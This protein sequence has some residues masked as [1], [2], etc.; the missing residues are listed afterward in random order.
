[1]QRDLAAIYDMLLH[2]SRIIETRRERSLD[3]LRA[4]DDLVSALLYHVIIL[5]EA[6]RRVSEQGRAQ[7]TLPWP[8]IV[9][10]RNVIVHDYD[11]V[12]LDLVWQIAKQDLP[13]LVEQL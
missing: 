5:G 10:L 3:D 1:M 6:A 7:W 9:G 13:P 2:A 8:K 4:D 12:D 11:E